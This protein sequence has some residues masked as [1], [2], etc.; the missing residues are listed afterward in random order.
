M[1]AYD[2]AEY[3]IPSSSC[4]CPILCPSNREIN[5]MVVL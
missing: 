3:I 4:F 1:P 2:K 5:T